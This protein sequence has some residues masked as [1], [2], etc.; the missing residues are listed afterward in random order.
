ML[1]T[2]GIVS[3]S[4]IQ[5]YGKLQRAA[6]G[7]DETVLIPAA[8]GRVDLSIY[9]RGHPGYP[10]KSRWQPYTAYYATISCVLIVFFNGWGTLVPPVAT[11]DFFGCYTAVRHHSPF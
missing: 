7:Q 11:G 6:T 10:F 4:Y 5:F 3:A 9:Q 8:D 2:Y 1:I